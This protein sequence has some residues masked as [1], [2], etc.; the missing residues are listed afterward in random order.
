MRHRQEVVARDV[1]NT[2]VALGAE[3]A[4]GPASARPV[5]AD[6]VGSNPP[7]RSSG[8]C[9]DLRTGHVPY[10]YSSARLAPRHRA[11]LPM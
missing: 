2:V 4:I 1:A 8:P 11:W 3:P 10:S 6:P 9:S 5:G 7:L